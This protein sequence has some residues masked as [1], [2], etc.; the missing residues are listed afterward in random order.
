[1]TEVIFATSI[2]ATTSFVP[3]CPAHAINTKLM[4]NL[5]TKVLTR[6]AKL[7]RSG[8]LPGD[9]STAKHC[10]EAPFLANLGSAY[11]AKP[12][13]CVDALRLIES[14]N[15]MWDLIVNLF[16]SLLVMSMTSATS[17]CKVKCE[18]GELFYCTL[19]VSGR[20][21]AGSSWLK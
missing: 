15:S 20:S 4:S 17:L 2:F 6:L 7:T 19:L 5:G 14:R 18:L 1:M 12:Y 9:E 13:L 16:W 8:D 3:K 10:P 21:L 11:P